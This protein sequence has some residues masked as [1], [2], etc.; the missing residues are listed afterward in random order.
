MWQTSIKTSKKHV[1]FTYQNKN[2]RHL[3]IFFTKKQTIIIITR[4]RN[5]KRH[6]LQKHAN[7][8]ER[9]KAIHSEHERAR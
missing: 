4:E 2:I 6:V 8:L 1:K 3:Q 5:S 9:D 7:E